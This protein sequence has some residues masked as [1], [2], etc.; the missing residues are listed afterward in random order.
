M[1]NFSESLEL[2]GF[3]KF[4]LYIYKNPAKTRYYDMT[5][6]GKEFFMTLRLATYVIIYNYLLTKPNEYE[7]DYSGINWDE[8]AKRYYGVAFNFRKVLH[9]NK[10]ADFNKFKWHLGYDVESLMI[11][12]LKAI[13][14]RTSVVNIDI[15]TLKI[16]D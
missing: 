4:C 8:V 13:E 5:A 11:F 16:C 12:N 9:I 1:K 2:K 14:G 3:K 6:E 15:N 10:H 7:P